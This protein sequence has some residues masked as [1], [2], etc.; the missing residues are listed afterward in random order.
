MKDEA[1]SWA[2]SVKEEREV[3]EALQRAE[4]ADS[5]DT[6]WANVT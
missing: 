3:T 4:H 6:S 5:A 1:E 2:L